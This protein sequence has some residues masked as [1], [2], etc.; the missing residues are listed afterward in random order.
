MYNRYIPAE[1]GTY[2]KIPEEEPQ[3]GGPVSGGEERRGP[4]DLGGLLRQ[5]LDR[6]QLDNIDSGDLMLL[7]LL[8]FLFR[9]KADEE[10]L[11]ALG[12]L[13]IL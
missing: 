12:L 8:F 7:A 2:E 10:V 1:D 3:T 5:L 9:E 13:L 6:F 4:E 11:V